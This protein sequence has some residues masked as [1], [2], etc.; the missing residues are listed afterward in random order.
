MCVDNAISHIIIISLQFRQALFLRIFDT[1]NVNRLIIIFRI[2]IRDSISLIKDF[3][4]FIKSEQF[5]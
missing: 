2:I 5:F 1:Q 4:L 3:E